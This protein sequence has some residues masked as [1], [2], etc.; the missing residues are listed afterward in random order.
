[1]RIFLLLL[2]FALAGCTKQTQYIRA[3]GQAVSQAQ[4]DAASAACANESQDR[5]CMVELGYFPVQA[6]QAETKRAQLAA[7]AAAEEQKRQAELA[8]L[9]AEQ[10]RIAQAEGFAKKKLQRRRTAESKN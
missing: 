6:D 9:A 8:A 2:I 4:V 3:D 1:M 10:A 7:I 5:F